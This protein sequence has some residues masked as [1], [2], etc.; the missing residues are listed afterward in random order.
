MSATKI[1]DS[2]PWFP[3]AKVHVVGDRLIYT[4]ER[5]VKRRVT[6]KRGLLEGFVRLSGL[7]DDDIRF[8]ASRWGVLG[9]CPCGLP[10]T[11]NAPRAW[12][13]MSPFVR[14]CAPLGAHEERRSDGLW[15]EPLADWKRWS[16]QAASVLRIV[17][18]LRAG[19]LPRGD[20]WA[21][22]YS[23]SNRRAPWWKRSVVGERARIAEV[24][25]EWLELGDVRP[26]LRWEHWQS[27]PA[28]VR[29]AQPGLFA[30]VAYQLALSLTMRDVMAICSNCG[31]GYFPSRKPSPGSR[32]FCDDCREQSAPQSAALADHRER[33]RT[34]KSLFDEGLTADEVA[35]RI[36]SRE[37]TVAR[38]F[39]AWSA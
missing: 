13:R 7:S 12:S 17:D 39:T 38:W 6:H 37:T 27:K 5:N 2:E 33:K 28:A 24:I 29:M 35:S 3:P 22:I 18:S 11:H 26:A 20:E 19:E 9:I 30:A 4:P 23:Q 21:V 15:W 16:R 25:D 1:L 8:F 34:A 10:A 32:R 36:G 14:H 31:Y